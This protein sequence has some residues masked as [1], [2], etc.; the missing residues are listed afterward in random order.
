MGM[1]SKKISNRSRTPQS[2]EFLKFISEN[3]A[4]Q[5][6]VT[7]E[8]WEVATYAAK[9]RADLAKSFKGKVLVIEDNQDAARTLAELL[10][11]SGNE[12]QLAFD[13]AS[14]GPGNWCASWA[15]TRRRRWIR[16]WAT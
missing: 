10:E 4:E 3:W 15:P 12:V 8:L 5:P 2:A 9:R 1:S 14:G 6:Q 16:T 13:G 11:L 7:P